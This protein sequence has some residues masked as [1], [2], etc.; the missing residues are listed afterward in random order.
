IRPSAAAGIG[1]EVRLSLEEPIHR[2][3]LAAEI[4]AAA[5]LVDPSRARIF[6]NGALINNARARMRRVARA[7]VGAGSA[8]GELELLLGRGHGIPPRFLVTQRGL[9]IAA[10]HD[11]LSG[12]RGAGEMPPFSFA[13][14][15]L[16]R[17]IV[18]A[19]TAAGY[20]IVVD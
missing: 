3:A 4:A 13:E 8:F 19:I 6:V 17:D 14:R 11:G 1:T 10:R 9:L 2:D 18:Q 16:H 20:G 12:G 7:E 15:S 5:G